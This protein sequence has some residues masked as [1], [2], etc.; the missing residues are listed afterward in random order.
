MT[1]FISNRR[2]LFFYLAR[3]VPVVEAVTRKAHGVMT[4]KRL[5]WQRRSAIPE[6]GY[7]YAVADAGANPVKVF[8]GVITPILDLI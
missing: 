3:L 8:L 1:K 7:L 2:L 6:R 5:C 4:G